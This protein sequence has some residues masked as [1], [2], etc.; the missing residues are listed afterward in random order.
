MFNSDTLIELI[1]PASLSKEMF[2]SQHEI[3]DN[4]L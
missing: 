4:L 2:K 3:I 1:H